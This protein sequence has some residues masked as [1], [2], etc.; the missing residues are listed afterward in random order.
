MNMSPKFHDPSI[1]DRDGKL[2]RHRF[3]DGSPRYTVCMACGKG[4]Q[5]QMTITGPFI[6]L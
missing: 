1:R 5:S 2:L 6:H 4:P 3:V